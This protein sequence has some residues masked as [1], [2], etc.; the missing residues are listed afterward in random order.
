MSSEQIVYRLQAHADVK[1]AH[2]F[3][4]PLTIAAG[5]M[6]RLLRCTAQSR[7]YGYRIQVTLF[8]REGYDEVTGERPL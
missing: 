5:P 2:K 6:L 4:Y 3:H 8:D 7:A 1:P